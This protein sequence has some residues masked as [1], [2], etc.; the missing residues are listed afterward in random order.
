MK[1]IRKHPCINGQSG[2][3]CIGTRQVGPVQNMNLYIATRSQQNQRLTA[4]LP[5]RKHRSLLP[6][7]RNV[8]GV[9]AIDP[10]PEASFGHLVYIFFVEENS[11]LLNCTKNSTAILTGEYSLLLKLIGLLVTLT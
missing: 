7:N 6:N 9:L 1:L 5:D 10:Y 11:N 4:R 3:G 2:N 8:D